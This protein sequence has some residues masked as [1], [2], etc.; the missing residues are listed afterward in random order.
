MRSVTPEKAVAGV[1][2]AFWPGIGLVALAHR[3][4]GI[5]LRDDLPF[6]A[7]G[8]LHGARL[9]AATGETW[10]TLPVRRATAGAPIA[11]I[12]LAPPETWAPRVMRAI[13]HAFADAPY[14]ENY[15][16]EIARL[17]FHEWPGLVD[18]D[19]EMLR[20][21]LRA[22]GAADRV[23]RATDLASSPPALPAGRRCRSAGIADRSALEVLLWHGPGARRLLAGREAPGPRAAGQRRAFRRGPVGP[24]VAHVPPA[25]ATSGPSRG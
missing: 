23:M 19:L 16:C 12:T 14:F 1:L 6:D 4:E 2:P 3:R 11:A 9:P 17:L 21:L 15:R 10:I 8:G 25:S 18:L 24:L 22:Y 13:E 20:L 7:S 5:V